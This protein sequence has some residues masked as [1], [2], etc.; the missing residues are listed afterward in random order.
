MKARCSAPFPSGSFTAAT[1]TRWKKRS[2]RCLVNEPEHAPAFSSFRAVLLGGALLVVILGGAIVAR[3][4]SP[5][6]RPLRHQAAAPSQPRPIV[7]IVR[8]QP[9]LPDLADLVDRLCP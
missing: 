2:G 3:S 4:L 9:G 7:E 1:R 6:R 8:Q 5:A